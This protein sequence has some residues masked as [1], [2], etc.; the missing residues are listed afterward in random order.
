MYTHDNDTHLVRFL[1]LALIQILTTSRK[2]CEGYSIKLV[3]C[4]VQW[5]TEALGGL[6][7]EINS[8]YQDHINV[9]RKVLRDMACMQVQQRK[10]LDAGTIEQKII[11]KGKSYPM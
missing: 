1:N 10:M 2:E 11:I 5:I 9:I 4:E 3:R 8:R 7:L 6:E